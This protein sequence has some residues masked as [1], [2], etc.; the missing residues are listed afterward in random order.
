MKCI[1]TRLLGCVALCVVSACS[2]TKATPAPTSEPAAASSATPTATAAETVAT[3]ADRL[4]VPARVVDLHRSLFEP[5]AK[6][7]PGGKLHCLITVHDGKLS[8][9]QFYAVALFGGGM[10]ATWTQSPS[11]KVEPF[12]A[13][14]T[15]EEYKRALGWLG[16]LAKDRGAAADRF[17]PSTTV[18]GIST[19]PGATSYFASDQTPESLDG[20]AKLLKHRLEATNAR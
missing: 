4:P 8:H 5:S 17:A 13:K 14:L 19:Q 16:E 18:M 9:D 6:P 20:L 11:G 10:V 15:D 2:A 1:S 12:T 3:D 7:V